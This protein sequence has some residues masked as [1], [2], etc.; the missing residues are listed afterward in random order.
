MLLAVAMLIVSCQQD[1]APVRAACGGGDAPG[2]AVVSETRL[3][4]D[5]AALAADS[6]QGRAL[7]TEGGRKARRYLEGRIRSLRLDTLGALV[8]PFAAPTREDSSRQG[9]NLVAYV[10]GARAKG[11]WLLVTAHYD[12]VGMRG[13]E[14]YN[15]A[16]D[17]ASGT[18]ALLALAEHLRAHPPAHPVMLVWLDGEERGLRG[19]AALIA[20]PPVPLADVA[21]NV[22]LDMVGRSVR[23]ELY[24]TGPAHRPWL[25][26]YVRRAACA[27]TATLMLGHDKGSSRGDDWTNQSDHFRFH[28]AGIPFLY[29]GVED[30]PDYHRPTDDVER[31]EPAFLAA[32]TRAAIGLVTALDADLDAIHRRR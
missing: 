22:N 7:G 32:T 30:H 24:V 17:N 5:V 4:A 9:A 16:D 6:M 14:I 19:S 23:K 21:A 3:M 18:A 12:H 31:I 2:P 20:A 27:T 15:G 1:P 29:L 13:S 10:P 28:E 25:T 26:A 8:R 11:P